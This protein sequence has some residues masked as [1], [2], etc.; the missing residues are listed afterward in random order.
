[1]VHEAGFPPVVYNYLN[2]EGRIVREAMSRHPDIDMMSITNSTR[3]GVAVAKADKIKRVHQAL[4][5]PIRQ[6]LR[7]R[8]DLWPHRLHRDEGQCHGTPDRSPIARADWDAASPFGRLQAVRQ[9]PRTRRISAFLE[10]K[11]TGAYQSGIYADDPYR[12]HGFQNLRFIAKYFGMALPASFSQK[13]QGPPP[14]V[15]PSPT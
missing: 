15:T 7:Q 4:G 2:G 13:G 9:R 8:H 1:M 10:I 3:A 11:A 5:R 14:N 12:K 6:H